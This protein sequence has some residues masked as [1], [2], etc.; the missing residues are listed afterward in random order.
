MKIINNLIN[1]LFVNLEK[2]NF[3]WRVIAPTIFILCISCLILKNTNPNIPFFVSTFSR[4]LIW[5]LLGC[6]MFFMIQWFRIQFLHEYAYHLYLVIM[7]LIFITLFM[8]VIGGSSRWIF[9]GNLSFQPSEI[10]KLLLVFTLARFISDYQGK[11]D[12]IKLLLISLG[13]ALVPCFIIFIQPD[14]GTAIVY[15]FIVLPMLF[16]GGMQV[17]YLFSIIAPFISIIS[18]FDLTFFSIWML[19]FSVV[20]YLHQPK[21]VYGS[22]NFLINVFCGVLSP[23]IWNNILYDHQRNRI[24][25]LLNPMNDPQGTGYQV[26]QSMTA[27]GSGGFWGKGLGS[28]TQTQLRFLPVRDTDFI[29]S[30]IGE[31]MGLFGI[32][33]LLIAFSII[34]Y[35][36]IGFAD[37]ISNRFCSLSLIGFASILFV[38]LIVNM[39][40]T[41]GLFPVTGLPVPFL[42]YG[43]SFLLTC[44]LI[45]GL[46]NNMISQ[47]I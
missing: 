38:H 34:F 4:Q 6:V 44:F 3:S 19:I 45:L 16:W 11:I 8:P 15:A 46:A 31:E 13:I 29:I 24:S 36:L 37:T 43:G 20:L 39:G 9:I 7:V 21:M 17:F 33:L 28:G 25:T 42:S 27:I 14:F 35:W 32:V 1:K 5:I 26:I 10:G 12:D 40:M 41:V 30:V 23:F 22:I 47:N 18:A 2:L